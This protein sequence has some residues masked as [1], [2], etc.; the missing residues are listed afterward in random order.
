MLANNLPTT[1]VHDLIV[2]PR[3]DMLVIAT[4][5][6]GMYALDVR[7][8]QAHGQPEAEKTAENATETSEAQPAEEPAAKPEP[9]VEAKDDKDDDDDEVG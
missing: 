1:F 7:P 9:K 8:I 6:R 5:G 3:D 2:H 4:H